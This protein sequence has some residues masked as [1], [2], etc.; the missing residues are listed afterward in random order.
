MLKRRRV[1]KFGSKCSIYLFVFFLLIF[2][3]F[4]QCVFSQTPSPTPPIEEETISVDTNLVQMEAIVKDKK[5]KIVKDLTINDFELVEDGKVRPIEFFSFVPLGESDASRENVETG[6]QV[7][8]IKSQQ[9]RRTF[10]FLVS[11]PN[12]KLNTIINYRDFI[13]TKSVSFQQYRVRGIQ[14]SEKFLN[15]FITE[16]L[17]AND[18]VSI[19]DTEVNLGTLSTFTNDREVLLAAVKEMKDHVNKG[20][21]QTYTLSAFLRE[22]NFDLDIRNLIQQNLNTLQMA[23]SAVEQLQKVPG[24]KMVFLLS[25]GM[26]GNTALPGVDAIN[27]RL[28]RVIEKANQAKVTFYSLSLKDLG[29]GSAEAPPPPKSAQG[30]DS[31][32]MLA[33][34]TGGRMIMN[35]NDISVGF[36]EILKENTGYYQLA[37]SPDDA[38]TSKAYQVKV[39]LKRPG[40]VAQYRSSVYQG[41]VAESKETDT[42]ATVL[43]LLRTPFA[44]DTVKVKLATKYQAIDKKQGKFTTVVNIDPQLFEPKMLENGVRQVKLDLGIQIT[45]PDNTVVRQEVKRFSLKLSEESWR[46]TL[47]EGLIY[48]FDTTSGKS[49]TY[50]IKIAACINDSN[51]CGNANNLIAAK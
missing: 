29:E 36:N 47:K 12:I 18:L 40:L 26:L 11:N 31:M 44:S 41:A 8:G 5:G 35:T 1:S 38:S 16:N 23:E 32:K 24:Q 50:S 20:K 37:F 30:E 43:K 10:V 15:K 7:K 51:K 28:K 19:N 49:G 4:N 14:K 6:N 21:N 48:Q 17:T 9:V 25:R 46:Q 33:E 39:N 34:K 42:K 27:L 22:G 13:D 2:S 45:E 3:F